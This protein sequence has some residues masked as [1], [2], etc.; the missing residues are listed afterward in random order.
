MECIKPIA[1]ALEASERPISAPFPERLSCRLRKPLKSSTLPFQ[2]LRYFSLLFFKRFSFGISKRN[3]VEGQSMTALTWIC[4]DEQ[5][6]RS[7]DAQEEIRRLKQQLVL[8][9]RRIHELEEQLQ[10]Y[11]NSFI[12]DSS[13]WCGGS[14]WPASPCSSQK[15]TN[16]EKWLWQK[17]KSA[18]R[19]CFVIGVYIYKRVQSSGRLFVFFC[20][21]FGL[22]KCWPSMRFSCEI[23]DEVGPSGQCLAYLLSL[24][25]LAGRNASSCIWSFFI[26]VLNLLFFFFSFPC[27]L[28]C[29][30]PHRNWLGTFWFAR[31]PLNIL[32]LFFLFLDSCRLAWLGLYCV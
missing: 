24:E 23:G 19:H 26:F 11:K 25:V 20:F 12:G 5:L 16:W 27:E 21:I 9:D 32:F 8:K 30:L 4:C 6:R 28:S 29:G 13:A 7:N 14:S 2:E 31:K 15:P 17:S 18:A 3:V 10:R 1:L 22:K